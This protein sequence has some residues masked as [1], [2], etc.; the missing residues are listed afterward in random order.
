MTPRLTHVR[1]LVDNYRECHRF[2][3][4]VLGFTPRFGG[5]EGVYEE[6]SA[7]SSSGVVLA[8]YQR[9]MMASVVGTGDLPARVEAQDRVALTFA[10]ESVDAAYDALSAMGIAFLGP[11]SDKPE[12]LMRVVHL[13]DPAGNLI[14]LNAPLGAETSEE[15]DVANETDME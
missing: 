9:G 2:Y 1:L 8:L 13:R 15:S 7:G 11:P 5:A 12:W 10:V 6:F 14:E 3:R 4:E